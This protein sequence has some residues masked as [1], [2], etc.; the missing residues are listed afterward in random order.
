M[1]F[2]IAQLTS[3]HV[4]KPKDDTFDVPPH[5]VRKVNPTGAGDC[6]NAAFI[7]GLSRGWSLKTT[8]RY[9]SAV[10]ALATTRLGPMGGTFAYQY[11]A[12]FMAS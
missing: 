12:D 10:G 4:R 5:K 2:V 7:V 8:A 6:Y 9:A 3:H 1:L 11:V